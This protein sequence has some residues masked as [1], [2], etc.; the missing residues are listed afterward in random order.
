MFEPDPEELDSVTFVGTRRSSK[1]SNVR[2]YVGTSCRRRRRF[3]GFN[4]RHAEAARSQSSKTLSQIR[5]S[6]IQNLAERGFRMFTVSRGGKAPQAHLGR[7]KHERRLRLK[8]FYPQYVHRRGEI[9]RTWPTAPQA[10]SKLFRN[11]ASLLSNRLLLAQKRTPAMQFAES[12]HSPPPR[13][14]PLRPTNFEDFKMLSN[15]AIR[16]CG[17]LRTS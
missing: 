9:V 12:S 6:A 14:T 7:K 5:S 1:L 8:R 13:T 10:K 15:A 11:L 4:V 2:R 17:T 16:A 3:N